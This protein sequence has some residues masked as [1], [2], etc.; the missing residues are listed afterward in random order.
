MI[1]TITE[2][3]TRRFFRQLVI[4]IFV[5]IGHGVARVVKAEHSTLSQAL[6]DSI[7]SITVRRLGP[8]A[9]SF[10]FAAEFRSDGSSQPDLIC[11]VFEHFVNK[12]L[13]LS[14]IVKT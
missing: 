12:L 10:R 1:E 14:F 9:F 11:A 4:R 3:P 5:T 6:K 8:C 13:N 7:E 2:I